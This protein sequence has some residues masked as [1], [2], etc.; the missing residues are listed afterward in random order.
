VTTVS[1]D[2]PC[3]LPAASSP[4]ARIRWW[5]TRTGRIRRSLPRRPLLDDAGRDRYEVIACTDILRGAAVGI[6]VDFGQQMLSRHASLSFLSRLWHSERVGDF[7]AGP[8][9][10][11]QAVWNHADQGD[12][13]GRL[14]QQSPETAEMRLERDFGQQLEFRLTLW[15]SLLAM[16]ADGGGV[17]YA[18]CCDDPARLEIRQIDGG[19][20]VEV[21]ADFVGTLGAIQQRPDGESVQFH[22]A[23]L[24]VGVIGTYPVRAPW[25]ALPRS[26]SIRRLSETS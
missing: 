3:V 26:A 25:D 13:V 22:N 11:P 24:A 2:R 5:F 9:R 18:A 23:D 4:P 15:E 21:S 1:G 19:V 8:V 16:R 6:D 14:N 17:R 20:D 10:V 12:A 7:L